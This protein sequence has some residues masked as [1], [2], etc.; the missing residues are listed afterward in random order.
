MDRINLST[1]GSVFGAV[2]LLCCI[3]YDHYKKRELNFKKKLQKRREIMQKMTAID[4]KDI[5][6]PRE[7][8]A[9]IL[10]EIEL[11]EELMVRNKCN[12]AVHHFVNAIVICEDPENI[13]RALQHSLPSKAYDLL[14]EVLT[15]HYGNRFKKFPG[16][17]RKPSKIPRLRSFY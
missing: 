6:D 4:L 17:D 1:I 3:V 14:V 2:M 9:F 8:Q 15:E 10:H 7:Q 5:Y 13:I 16:K 11:A 12:E